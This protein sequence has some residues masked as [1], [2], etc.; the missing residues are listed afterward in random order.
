MT[1]LEPGG[2]RTNWGRRAFDNRPSM[3]PEYQ[4]SVGKVLAQLESYWG[5]EPGDPEKVAEIVLKV[6]N[7]ETLPAHI[8]LG[9]DSVKMIRQIEEARM[10]DAERWSAVSDWIDFAEEGQMPALP[11]P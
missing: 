10:V 8:L 9:R 4:E 7:A 2:M 5:N 3:L 6:A 1:A 11:T